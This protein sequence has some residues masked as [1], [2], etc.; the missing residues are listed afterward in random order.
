MVRG[1]EVWLSYAVLRMGM[2]VWKA[3]GCVR[4]YRFPH[5][6]NPLHS[7]DLCCA[8][9]KLKI[10]SKS[11][12]NKNDLITLSDSYLNYEIREGPILW[13]SQSKS[14]NGQCNS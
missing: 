11:E 14:P 8:S 12:H 7:N 9:F 4:C 13:F 3:P 1:Q 10:K 2:K 5:G 6:F